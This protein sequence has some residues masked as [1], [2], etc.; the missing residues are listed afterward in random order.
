MD[1]PSRATAMRS[2][3]CQSVWCW[4]DKEEE[5]EEEEEED[6]S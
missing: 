3:L 6:N 2:V 4:L 1:V 5:E